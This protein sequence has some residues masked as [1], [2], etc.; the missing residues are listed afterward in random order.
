MTDAIR[1][2]TSPKKQT[3]AAAAPAAGFPIAVVIRG[4]GANDN[5]RIDF[6]HVVGGQVFNFSSLLAW[7]QDG[8][9]DEKGA[10][11]KAAA[12]TV[13]AIAAQP[14]QKFPM[15]SLVCLRLP[16]VLEHFSVDV[17]VGFG[18]DVTGHIASK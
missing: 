17:Y 18:V 12:T 15:P 1:T 14:P 16:A 10:C 7:G 2:A 4:C 6:V 13:G 9:D 5:S 11:T 3:F 8:S